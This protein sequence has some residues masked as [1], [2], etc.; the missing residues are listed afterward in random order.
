M[1][2]ME[3]TCLLRE[4]IPSEQKVA[5]LVEL[6]LFDVSILW[7]VVSMHVSEAKCECM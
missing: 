2:S 6:L 4:R 5:Q 3:V 1:K 7:H